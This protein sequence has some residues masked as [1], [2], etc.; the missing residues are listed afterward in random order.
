MWSVTVSRASLSL[1]ELTIDGNWTATSPNGGKFHL[2]EDGCTWPSFSIRRKYAPDSDDVPGRLL[3]GAVRDAGQ[4]TLAV[5]VHQSSTASIKTA[6]AELEAAFS[7]LFYN[8]TLTVD[9]VEIGTWQ[10][11]A[12]LPQWGSLDSGQ[13]RGKILKGTIVIPLNP[14]VA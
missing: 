4:M 1:P 10:A 12:E 13:V 5:D 9:G 2:A 8:L 3:V 14:A 7:Q 6:A 11:Q